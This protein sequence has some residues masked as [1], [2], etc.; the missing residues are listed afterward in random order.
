MRIT[1]N[2]CAIAKVLL[3]AT[4]IANYAKADWVSLNNYGGTP[5]SPQLNQSSTLASIQI[6]FNLP[7]FA[8]HNLAI[9]QDT[10]Q[11]LEILSGGRLADIGKPELPCFSRFFIIPAGADIDVS[12]NINSSVIIDDLHIFPAQPPQIDRIGAPEEPFTIDEKFYA[13]DVLYPENIVEVSKPII[14]RGVNLVSVTII[15][16]K[17]NPAKNQLTVYN[18]LDIALNF[19]GGTELE[20]PARLYSETFFEFITSLVVN[21]G[22]LPRIDRGNIRLSDTGAE[23]LVISAP[24]FMDAAREFVVWKNQCGIDTELRSTTET[25]GTASEIEAYIQNAYDTW[26]PVPVYILLVGDAEFVPVHYSDIHPYYGDVR[27]GTDLYYVTTDGT[28]IFPDIFHGRISCDT[29]EQADTI[30]HKI[31]NYERNPVEDNPAFYNTINFAAYFQDSNNNGTADRFFLQRTEEVRT[32]MMTKGYTGNRIYV[33]SSSNPRWYYYGEPLPPDIVF[34]GS[35][36]MI[37]QR[38]QEGGFILQHRDH[39]ST[40]GWGEPE[41]EVPHVNALQNGNLL[42]VVFSINCETGWFDNETDQAPANTPVGDVYFCEAFQRNPNGGAVA[43]FGHTRVSYSGYNDEMFKGFYDAIW[44]DFDP[45]Y[46]APNSTQPILRPQYRLGAALNFAKFWM[47]DK[48]YLTS[49]EG[50]PWTPTYD[51][52][53]L[54]FEMMHLFGDP[55]MQIYTAEPQNLTVAHNSIINVGQTQFVIQVDQDSALGCLWM[56]GTILGRGLSSGGSIVLNLD[57]GPDSIGYA[58]VSVTKHNYRVYQDSITVINYGY[59]ILKGRLTD[60]V[61]ADGLPGR[62][63]II[64]REPVITGFC[65]ASGYYSMA[66]PID[67]TWQL[68]AEYNSDYLPSFDTVS[69]TE[70]DTSYVDF[71]LEP[72]VDAVVKVSFGNPQAIAY[73]NFYVRGSWDDDGF[74]NPNWNCAFSEIKDDGVAPDT[75]EGDGIFTGLIKLACDPQHTYQWAVYSENYSDS[76]RLQTGSGFIISSPGSAPD[77]P[78]LAVN[79][80]GSENNW[81]LTVEG[82]PGLEIELQPGYDG[83]PYQWSGIFQLIEGTTYDFRVYPMHSTV[84]SYGLGGVG[85]GDYGIIANTTITLTFVFD[86]LL[87]TVFINS[88]FPAPE[89]LTA[90]I[91]MD[92][93]INLNWEA[94]EASPEYYKIYRALNSSGPFELIDS[95]LSQNQTYTDQ[96]V[97]NYQDYYYYVTSI[98]TGNIES[99]SSNVAHGYAITGARMSVAPLSF[100]VIV[101]AGHTVTEVLQVSNGG[102]LD[103]NYIAFTNTE[104]IAAGSNNHN[105]EPFTIIEDS[106]DKTNLTPEPIFPPMTLDSGGPDEY[107]YRWIDSDETG[108]PVYNWIDITT[109]GTRLQMSDDSNQGPFLMEFLF[110]FYG[111]YYSSY[112]ICANGFVSFTSSAPNRAN[113]PLPSAEEPFNLLAGFWDDLNPTSST[114]VYYY[115]SSDSSIISFVDVPRYGSGGPYTFQIIIISNGLIVFQYEDM[116]TP[117]NSATIGIQNGDGTIG[118][119]V[120]YNQ[121]YI[122]SN[123]AIRFCR[124]WLRADPSTGT[125]APDET[126]PVEIIFDATLYDEGTYT[127]YIDLQ[128]FDIYH[129]EETIRIPA[130]MRVLPVGINDDSETNIPSAYELYQNYPNPFNA[131]TLINY[132]LPVSAEVRLEIYNILGQRVETLVNENQPPG[133]YHITWNT[134]GLPSGIYFYRMTADSETITKKMILLR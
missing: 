84:A 10:Y 74:Y 93:Q 36:Q 68:R 15:P 33:T 9:N 44:L 122:H 113:D 134:D 124:G 61:T 26:D 8:S 87:D 76:A 7:G 57:D 117:Y 70:N 69:V 115:N 97:T 123:M 20:I 108:G 88:D 107:G 43:V 126:F 127:G 132:D 39:G 12:V 16:F 21:P 1:K 100:D 130:T 116:S 2:L 114:G 94:P 59:G 92:E 110:P 18:D 23:Y 62:V 81:T 31:I 38:V 25:G 35:T 121:Y 77:I 119:Q 24:D 49:G 83:F 75:A 17:Y 105:L 3:F 73:R 37:T 13:A 67:T 27:T 53:K 46:P 106:D 133:R 51:K 41:Y 96:P 109:I 29:E 128:G 28:D 5:A 71:A 50:Y 118:L 65:N 78:V 14:V 99:L 82:N 55:S 22:L 85:G 54:E 90:T 125:V 48:Y 56:N 32:F 11:K 72:K 103:L 131:T 120:V 111:N 64:N 42:P 34:N 102:D 40:D 63:S 129:S 58:V 86:D 95:V 4:I 52:T 45:D 60:M 19:S 101:D 66:I 79:P 98:Y 104:D 30:F 47:Y 80:S 112:R 91:D 6:N 89:S